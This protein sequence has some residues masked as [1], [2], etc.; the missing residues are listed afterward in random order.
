MLCYVVH[1]TL[2]P[3]P[4]TCREACPQED[5]QHPG[6]LPGTQSG[7]V[8]LRVLHPSRQRRMIRHKNMAWQRLS[9]LS[10]VECK[11]MQLLQLSPNHSKSG[12]FV[13]RVL[14]EAAAYVGLMPVKALTRTKIQQDHLRCRAV[15]G[16]GMRHAHIVVTRKVDRKV[17]S[18][19]L[20]E[21]LHYQA[22]AARCT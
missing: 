15:R 17:R 12:R 22:A 3:R 7:C 6:D 1:S 14:M 11:T 5:S 18:T 9:R 10:T 16:S 8:W 2:K 13:P 19:L 20:P 21:G 4:T